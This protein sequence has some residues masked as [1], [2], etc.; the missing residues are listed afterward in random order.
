MFLEEFFIVAFDDFNVKVS[1]FGLDNG[2]SGD[3]DIL[4][5][6]ELFSFAFMEIIRHVKGL[7]T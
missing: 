4:I 2:L 3:E 6:E 7:S 1:G 5:D